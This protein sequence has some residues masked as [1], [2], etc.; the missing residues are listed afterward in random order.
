MVLV[1]SFLLLGL[2][3][4]MQ[5]MGVFGGAIVVGIAFAASF[6]LQIT[7]ASIVGI[8][9]GLLAFILA[10]KATSIDNWNTQVVL[11]VIIF[12]LIVG[13]PAVSWA[14][15]ALA[16]VIVAHIVMVSLGSMFGAAMCF[17]AITLPEPRGKGRQW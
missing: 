10:L 9:A 11:G 8:L 14:I 16:P 7:L 6:G 3:K 2:M 13:A 5:Q 1:P 4:H 12:V 15:Y 17:Y